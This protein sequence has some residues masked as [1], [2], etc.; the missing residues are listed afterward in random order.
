MELLLQNFL[1]INIYLPLFLSANIFIMIFMNI[2]IDIVNNFCN[3]KIYYQQ[4]YFI[5]YL[6]GTPR[7]QTFTVLS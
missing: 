1:H 2:I 4:A 6:E 7:A 5:K 3:Y